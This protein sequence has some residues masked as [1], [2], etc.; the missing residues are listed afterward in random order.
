M[1]QFLPATCIIG[2]VKSQK[3]KLLKILN[4][5]TCYGKNEIRDHAF[6]SRFLVNIRSVTIIYVLKILFVATL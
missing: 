1:T 3:T 2:R 6:S 4:S 5:K